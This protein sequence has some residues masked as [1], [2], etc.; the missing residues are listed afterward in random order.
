[1]AWP[2]GKNRARVDGVRR[3]ALVIRTAATVGNYGGTISP[4]AS[5][6]L[7]IDIARPHRT[8]WRVLRPGYLTFARRLGCRLHHGR[9]VRR[10]LG[11]LLWPARVR[12]SCSAPVKASLRPGMLSGSCTCMQMKWLCV[13]F[14]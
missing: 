12:P 11:G 8:I 2:A 1:M 3:V 13:V 10:P 4:D 9:E 14:A 5:P 7:E 6:R